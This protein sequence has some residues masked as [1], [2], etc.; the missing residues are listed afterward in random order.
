MSNSTPPQWNPNGN[1][2]PSTPI[3][4]WQGVKVIGWLAVFAGII[5]PLSIVAWRIA[6]GPLG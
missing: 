4:Q 6:T 3:T 5:L 1:N 2:G